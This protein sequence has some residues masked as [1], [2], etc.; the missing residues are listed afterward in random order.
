MMIWYFGTVVLSILFT[1]KEFVEDTIDKGNNSEYDE[2]VEYLGLW[3]R[4]TGS[5][6]FSCVTLYAAFTV[7]Y[8][9]FK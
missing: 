9:Q 8:K 4:E 6:L 3:I 5:W 7:L 1:V 2:A